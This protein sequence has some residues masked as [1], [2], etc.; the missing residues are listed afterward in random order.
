MY[1]VFFQFRAEPAYRQ[2]VLDALL[3]DAR[4][5]RTHEPG[6]IRFEVIED[7]HRPNDLYVYGVYRDR[8]AFDAHYTGPNFRR[9]QDVADERWLAAPVVV[10]GRGTILNPP[11]ERQ[12]ASG[13]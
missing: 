12:T 6:T 7:E 8:E 2:R 3:Q 1:A 5:S 4:A 11:P 9:W 13:A 10:L